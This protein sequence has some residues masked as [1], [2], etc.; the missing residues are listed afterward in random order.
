M[1]NKKVYF[2]DLKESLYFYLR[3]LCPQKLSILLDWLSLLAVLVTLL[4]LLYL[5][6]PIERGFFCHDLSIHYPYHDSSIITS[7]NNVICYGVPLIMI[8]VRS[9]SHKIENYSE[10]PILREASFFLFG[11]L[12]VQVKLS[13]Y[14]LRLLFITDPYL[15]DAEQC[16]QILCWKT[17][18]S[19]YRCV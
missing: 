18:A 13:I 14:A 12:T 6:E 16:H 19:F 15:S 1:Y 4:F 17:E 9:C 2:S 7:V 11:V 5:R 3:I 10:K 8:F